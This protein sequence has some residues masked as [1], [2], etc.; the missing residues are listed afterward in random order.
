MVGLCRDW[1]VKYLP[2]QFDVL[3]APTRRPH[4]RFREITRALDRIWIGTIVKDIPKLSGFQQ[5]RNQSS[6]GSYKAGGKACQ[7]R[8]MLDLE[9]CVQ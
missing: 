1:I 9:P 7:N 5:T 3:W 6:E 2:E 8:A 4:S